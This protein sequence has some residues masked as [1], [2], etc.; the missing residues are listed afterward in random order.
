MSTPAEHAIRALGIDAGTSG[1]RVVAL[2]RAGQL[3]GHWRVALPSP[4]V[5]GP[6]VFQDPGVWAEALDALMVTVAKQAD[7]SA[8]AAIAIDGTSGTVLPV[9]AVSGAVLGPALMYNDR[10]AIRQAARIGAGAPPESGAHGAGSSL[11]KWL[12]MASEQALGPNA[13]PAHQADWLLTRWLAG[14][15]QVQS[16]ENNALKLG[17]DPVQRRWPG[18]LDAFLPEE[19]RPQVHVPGAVVGA[20]DRAVCRRLGLPAGVC[21]VAG[22]TDSIAGVHALGVAEPGEAVTSLGSTLAVKLVSDRPVFDPACGVYSHRFGCRFLVGG[23]SNTG[24][25]V[26]GRFFD[27]P[28]LARLSAKINPARASCLDYYP[29]NAPGERFPVNDPDLRP[30]LSPRP[31]DDARF[32]QGMF[33]AMARIERSGYRRLA[34]LGAPAVQHVRTVGGGA[35]NPVWTA[36]RQRV[37]GVPVSACPEA[38]AAK[39]AAR[40]ALSAV[41]RM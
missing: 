4:S 17:Y 35:A 7:L 26:L 25:A 34:A 12:W 13:V 18:W 21:L 6:R 11:A 28:A 32:L 30:R 33:E 22:T 3:R 20:M 8:L 24:G 36:I 29:L 1:I 41:D 19:A 9:D 5:D 14:D 31:R 27:P 10:R 23:A 16:D 15:G 39:G 38:E 40:L 2:D 37:L